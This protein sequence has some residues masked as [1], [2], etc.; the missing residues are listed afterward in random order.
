MKRRLDSRYCGIHSSSASRNA[1]RSVFASRTPRLRAA[2]GPRFSCRMRRTRS[3]LIRSTSWGLV[4]VEPSSTTTTSKSSCVCAS[5]DRTARSTVAALLYRGMT[6]VK[7]TG[8]ASGDHDAVP[9]QQVDVLRGE[10][11]ALHLLVVDRDPSQRA[12]RFHAQDERLVGGGESIRSAGKRDG[13]GDGEVL[14]RREA[15]RLLHH[16]D[17]GDEVAVDGG[18]GDRD[19]VLLVE[20]H[21]GLEKLPDIV[22]QLRRR[23]A[24]RLHLADERHGDRAVGSNG[25]GDRKVVVLP[26]VDVDRVAHVEDVFELERV[27]LAG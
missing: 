3:S 27:R 15:T 13:L 9:A 16:A 20:L 24:R 17:D 7:R 21:V 4:S 5:T 11:A 2:P 23:L 6:T 22:P 8:G 14:G 18:D 19:A 26:H 10:D 1:T 25:R 12:R